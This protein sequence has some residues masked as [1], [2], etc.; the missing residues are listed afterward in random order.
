[1]VSSFFFELCSWFSNQGIIQYIFN[2]S[3]DYDSN[4]ANIKNRTNVAMTDD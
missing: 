2:K 3:P 4:H 1:M